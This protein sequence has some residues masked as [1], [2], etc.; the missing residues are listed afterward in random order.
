MKFSEMPYTRPDVPK[1]LAAYADATA[2]FENASTAAEQLDLYKELEALESDFE[3]NMTLCSIRNSVNTR[4][5]YYEAE[6]AYCDEQEPLLQEAAH[7]F[8]E[9]LLASKF[10]PQ[11]EEKLGSLL[12][13]NLELAQKGFSPKVT[14]LVQEENALETQ[15]QK[16][17][18]SAKVQFD[19]KERNIAQLGPYKESTDAKTR[20]AAFEAEGSFFD[21]H[22]K[23]FDEIYDAMVKNRTAQAKALGYESYVQLGYIRQGRNCYTP[24]DVAAFRSLVVRDI[25]P[26]VKEIKE[27]QAK[28]LGLSHITLADDGLFFPDG[29]AVPQGTPDELMQAGQQMYREMSPETAAFIDQMFSMELFDVL[30]KEGKAPGGYCTDLPKYHCS[31]IFSN[32]NGTSGDVDVLTHEAGHAFAS[33]IADRT[34][35]VAALRS[36]SMEGCETHSMSM[37]FLTAPWHHLFFKDKTAPYEISHTESA[38]IFI[39]YGCLVDHFQELVYSAPDMTPAERNAAWLR[40]EGVYRPY[41]DFADLPFYSRGAGWQRQLHIYECPFYYI[42]Y[43]LAQTMSLQF[44]SAHR[45]DAKAAWEKYL[46]F[47]KLGGTKTFLD[48]VASAGMRS[49]FEDGCLKDIA[50]ETKDWLDSA[51]RAL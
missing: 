51:Y 30:A 46:A 22:Q 36:P 18:A 15:Y 44:F 31:F 24:R 47:V 13:S 33:Y 4:D 7:A 35:P 25:V 40:L 3:T 8:Q 21:A 20:R 6:R 17:Y 37:E 42:E 1:I 32:F 50:K 39:P 2:Q 9:K 45:K 26:V 43:C 41:L 27:A 12:F 28:R 5:P 34:I 11:L 29:N 16:L 14:K 48:L 19:G 23:E 10:R 49:P 38:L